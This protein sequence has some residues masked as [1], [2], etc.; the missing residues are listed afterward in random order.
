MNQQELSKAL[1]TPINDGDL[2]EVA[3]TH[4]SFANENTDVVH[5]E[6]LE[7][8][9]DAVIELIT[10][11][12]LYKKFPN[13]PEGKMTK[14]RSALVSGA[15]LAKVSRDLSFGEL[16]RLSRGEDASQGREKNPILAN[17]FEA[18]IGAIY[19]DSGYETAKQFLQTHLFPR[20]PEV[21]EKRLHV[22]PKSGFQEWAQEELEITPEYKMLSE[23]GPD[24]EKNYIFGVFVGDAKMGEGNG[25]SK[26]KAEVAA[27]ENAL[28]HIAAL[29][30]KERLTD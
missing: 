2:F 14:L 24:H 30:K 15:S 10:T 6:R 5:N 23:S 28:E 7:F 1:G 18:V 21:L 20:L 9:G 8:L 16:L 27:A 19:L 4:K 22:D 13:E 17:A 11:E 12:F 29:N 26:Q 3:F 25:T